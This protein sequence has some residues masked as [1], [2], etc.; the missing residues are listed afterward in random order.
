MARPQ[1]EFIQSQVLPWRADARLGLGEGVEVKTLSEDAASGAASLLV[2][3]PAGWTFPAGPR[4]ADEEFLVLDGRIEVGQSAFGYLHYGHWPAGY[5]PGARST[6]EG[7]IALTFVSGDPRAP[8]PGAFDRQ[9]LV[10][11]LDALAVTYTGNFHP[12]FPPGAGR[13][14]LFTDPASLETSWILG[15]LPLRWAERSEEHDHVEEMY[16]LSGESHG[17]RGVMRPGAYFWRPGHIAHGPYG[18]LTGNLYFFRS[19][20]GPLVTRYV[21]P[22]TPFR[23]FPP[24]RP[25]LPPEL[26]EV[27]AEAPPG[28][29]AW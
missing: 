18:T 15:T 24:Y 14:V 6:A 29:R 10:E 17:D 5:D 19:R 13:K 26:A 12:E 22:E 16:L 20:G 4:G 11:R 23:W 3:Y 28:A 9:R 8:S 21:D 2:R 7:A 27:S 1:V 25:A